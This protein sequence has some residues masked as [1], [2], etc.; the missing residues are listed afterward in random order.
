MGGDRAAAFWTWVVEPG[1]TP[2][3]A[4]PL[5]VRWTERDGAVVRELD[6]PAGEG[7]CG[8]GQWSLDGSRFSVQLYADSGIPVEYMWGDAVSGELGGMVSTQFTRGA[9]YVFLG[10]SFV[11]L[12]ES[13]D[14]TRTFG[15][16]YGA[17]A[18]SPELLF[19]ED[20]SCVG[21]QADRSGQRLAYGCWTSPDRTVVVRDLSMPGDEPQRLVAPNA[22]LGPSF[23]PG[24]GQLAWDHAGALWIADLGTHELLEVPELQ[25][26]ET[27]SPW[28]DETT[29]VAIAWA[30][31]E[32]VV[33][34]NEGEEYARAGGVRYDA[35]VVSGNVIV[36]TLAEAPIAHIFDRD[37]ERLAEIEL[38]D[39]GLL[40]RPVAAP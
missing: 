25:L 34:S 9:R 4:T 8:L 11:G 36:A 33:L 6:W 10:D 35:A 29:L 20:S 23:S 7:C 2:S 19:E 12:E 39:A 13:E 27:R 16:R 28:I 38:A 30:S 24:G 17:D 31:D 5:L 32:V 40:A 18:S 1:T 3:V 21:I 22:P 37:L 14:G 15:V 26:S